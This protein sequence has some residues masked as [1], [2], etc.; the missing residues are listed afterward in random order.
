MGYRHYI[1]YI[2]D[3]DLEKIDAMGIKGT[4]ELFNMLESKTTCLHELGK[5]YFTRQDV[6][7]VIYKNSQSLLPEEDYPDVEYFICD[8]DILLNVANAYRKRASEYYKEI[9]EKV[10]NE[11]GKDFKAGIG[12][13]IQNCHYKAMTI[14]GEFKKDGDMEINWEY[15]T[16]MFQLFYLHKTF[17][18]KGR[19]L[20]V[21]A[22]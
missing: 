12:E 6:Y 1:G 2:K 9:Y 20:V 15:E 5:L 8:K 4:Y 18:R 17:R 22:W 11:K 21:Y 10:K 13:L 16:L 3:S 14:G 19:T 7:D